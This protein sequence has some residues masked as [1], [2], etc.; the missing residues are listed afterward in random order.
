MGTLF[1]IWRPLVTETLLAT[2]EALATEEEIHV[3]FVQGG[4]VNV[5]DGNLL[6]RMSFAESLSCLD[7]DAEGVER[8]DHLGWMRL[9]EGCEKVVSWT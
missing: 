7:C 6:G 3:I 5:N 9:I 1:V 8:V 4:V 2:M